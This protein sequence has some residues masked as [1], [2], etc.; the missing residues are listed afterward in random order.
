M[1]MRPTWGSTPRLTDRQSQCD[2]DFQLSHFQ[3]PWKEAKIITLLKLGKDQKFP[4]NLC[5]ISLLSITGKLFEK[6]IQN[7]VQKHIEENSLLNSSK[8]D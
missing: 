6:V 3:K 8:T 5:P 7:G 4:K 2:F 1:V